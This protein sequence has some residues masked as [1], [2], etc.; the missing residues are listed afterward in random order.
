MAQRCLVTG[1]SSGIGGALAR[2]LAQRGVEV[3][4]A[5]RRLDSLE[6]A[7]QEITAAGGKAHAL[8]LDVSNPEETERAVRDL[9][10]AVGGI[11]IVVANAGIGGGTIPVAELTLAEARRVLDTNLTGALATILPLVPRMVGRGSGHVV[12]ISSLAA[13]IP[14][15][16]AAHYGTSKAA[17]SFFLECAACDL[18]PRGVDVTIVHPGFVRTPLTDKNSFAMPFM[19]ELERAAEVIDRGIASRARWVRFP[20][21][22]RA[23]ITSS[24]AMPTALRDAIVNR[25]RP[26]EG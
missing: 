5:A 24:K 21:P 6:Q 15:P 17:L 23:A 20:F 16:A 12:G 26:P 9:D 1:A 13:E 22:L 19:V 8:Q 11:D 3:W 7:V 14:L 18:R 10:E 4:L 2:R 25:A